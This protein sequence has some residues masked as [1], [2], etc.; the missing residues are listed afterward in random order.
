MQQARLNA[1]GR[2]KHGTEIN[3]SAY[4]WASEHEHTSVL[5]VAD[6]PLLGSIAA[7]QRAKSFCAGVRTSPGPGQVYPAQ[8]YKSLQSCLLKFKTRPIIKIHTKAV[9]KHFRL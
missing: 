3:I 1:Q 5:L 4:A 9:D 6:E 2:N 7:A 8:A